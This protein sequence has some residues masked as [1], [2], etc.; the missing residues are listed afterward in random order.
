MAVHTGELKR[1]ATGKG[2]A[3]K[4]EMIEPA[5]KKGWT[6]ADDNEAGAALLLEYSLNKL[7]PIT[8]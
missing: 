4:L 5:K 8:G 1:W 6:P 7:F 3:G 2:N